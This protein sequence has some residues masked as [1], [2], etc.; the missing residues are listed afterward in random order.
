M[1]QIYNKWIDLQQ[2]RYVLNRISEIAFLG[3]YGI[4]VITKTFGYV[5]YEVFFKLLFCLALI[6]WGVSV[7][8]SQ[9]TMREFLILYL[10]L[11]VSAV[12]WLRVGEKNVMFIT[13]CL[14]GMKNCN[15]ERLMKWTIGIR[16]IGTTLVMLLSF[17]GIMN[18][19]PGESMATDYRRIFVYAFGYIKANAAFYMVFVALVILLY[20]QYEK[21]NIWYFFLS[22]VVCYF[23]FQ[24]TYCRT[25]ALLFLAMWFFIVLDKVSI[26]K[27][28][29]V[30]MT[31]IVFALY[32][33]S[34]FMM[35]IYRKENPILFKINR[36]FNGRIEILANYDKA[37]G[38]TLFPKTADIF[39]NMNYTTMDNF[40]MYFFISCGLVVSLLYVF[41]ATRS[42]RMLYRK[43]NYREILF[44]TIFAIYAM[45]EQSPFNPILNP[46]ILLL[47]NQVYSNWEI[48]EKGYERKKKIANITS[49]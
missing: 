20:I 11:G 47:G 23:A 25:G 17:I 5:S 39:W 2:N 32:M 45:L 37:Y 7:V 34:F 48:A 36:V 40:Y 29:Y 21:L 46:F 15:F 19:Q 3:F 49:S 27:H 42:L 31:W 24:N 41:F 26:R 18:L 35:K 1:V 30:W 16:I 28:Y 6:F 12:C 10:L 33:L 44:F 38:T 4:M 43:G 9:Y 22:S 13:L 14:W 8:T